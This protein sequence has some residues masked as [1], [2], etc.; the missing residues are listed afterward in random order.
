MHSV[1]IIPEQFDTITYHSVCFKENIFLI[2]L[3]ILLQYDFR[4]LA[5]NPAWGHT[6]THTCAQSLFLPTFSNTCTYVCFRLFSTLRLS[7]HE[8]NR[9]RCYSCELGSFQTF[10]KF[11]RVRI[12]AFEISHKLSK[13][14]I[15]S[16]LRQLTRAIRMLNE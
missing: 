10:F 7:E 6:H 16:F 8:P 13:C 12:F 15:A 11:R 9:T 1:K 2:V 4:R 5:W 3:R 14:S